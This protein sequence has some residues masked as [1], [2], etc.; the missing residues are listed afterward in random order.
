MRAIFFLGNN[1]RMEG[2]IDMDHPF[3]IEAMLK[4]IEANR[5]TQEAVNPNKAAARTIVHKDGLEAFAEKYY[6]K[7]MRIWKLKKAFTPYEQDGKFID[8]SIYECDMAE[9]VFITDIYG[10]DGRILIGYTSVDGFDTSLVTG[11]GRVVCKLYDVDSKDFAFLDELELSYYKR[12]TEEF[13]TDGII[14]LTP[15]DVPDGAYEIGK[16]GE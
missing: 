8:Q 9:H 13:L 6:G 1:P 5:N 10:I 12:D 15:D 11:D 4:N 2:R 16:D 7:V 14:C 3:D